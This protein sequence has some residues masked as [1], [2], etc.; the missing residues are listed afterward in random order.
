[1]IASASFRTKASAAASGVGYCSTVPSP[2]VTG[3]REALLGLV[4]ALDK[5]SRGVVVVGSGDAARPDR[6]IAQV[7]T[8]AGTR[9]PSTVDTGGSVGGDLALV[10]AL[11]E[12]AGGHAGDYGRGEG[13]DALLPDV[14]GADTS[15]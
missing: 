1:M 5:G 13:A 8:S 7:R 2:A 10:L 14:A 11:A 3:A 6:L 12:Q 4:S 15:G 9:N